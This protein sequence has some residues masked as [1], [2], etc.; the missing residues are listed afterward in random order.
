MPRVWDNFIP[1]TSPEL[2]KKQAAQFGSEP[3]D[4]HPPPPPP[5]H[6]SLLTFRQKDTLSGG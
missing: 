1:V 2:K 5:I 3:V 6:F 4:P